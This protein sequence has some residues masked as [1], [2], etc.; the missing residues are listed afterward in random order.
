MGGIRLVARFTWKPETTGGADNYRRVCERLDLDPGHGSYGVLH[1]VA[2]DHSRETWIT[3]DEDYA[4][5]VEQAQQLI[6]SGIPGTAAGPLNGL[7]QAR[8]TFIR[9]PGW[10]ETWDPATPPRPLE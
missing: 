5:A 6:A 1:V 3:P 2:A 10:P 7:V 4:R 8:D 9:L